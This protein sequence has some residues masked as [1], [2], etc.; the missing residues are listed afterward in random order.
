[1][2]ARAPAQKLEEI[3]RVLY[4]TKV[5]IEMHTGFLAANLPL[6][7]DMRERGTGWGETECERQ[8]RERE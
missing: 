2:Q 5:K 7:T 1:M 3:M 6:I 8:T 4:F